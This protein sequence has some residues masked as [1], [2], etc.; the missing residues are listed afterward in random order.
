MTTTDQSYILTL[1]C[2]DKPG[3][4]AATSNFLV[5]QGCNI[6]E[7][8]QFEDS[9]TGQFFMRTVFSASELTPTHDELIGAYKA[10]G[11]RFD[12]NWDLSLSGQV[13]KVLIMASKA[14]H[15]L[16]DLLYRAQIQAIPMEV[17]SVVSNHMDQKPIADF[18]N[19]PYHHLPITKE[20][21]QEQE[22]SLMKIV[23]ETGAELIVLARYMQVLSSQLCEELSGRAINIHHS[24][25]PSFK[26]AMP[27]H[28]AHKRGVKLIGATA[29]FVT[30]DLD[31]GP[32]IEQEAVRVSHAHTPE[33]LVATGRDLES[34]VLARAVRLHCEKRVLR[35]GQKTVVFQK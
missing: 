21:K 19:V 26:G 12:M 11:K 29:H 18:H 20:N 31:E 3:I 22:A 24:F 33:Q 5:E 14:G 28:Q 17:V 15:C 13:T 1:S 34:V 23:E 16:N 27:Y 32:I 6:E 30:T 35:N 25:L 7:S 4:V 8:A 9:E 2:P 10:I